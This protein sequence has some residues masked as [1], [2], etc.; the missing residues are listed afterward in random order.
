MMSF[1][2]IPFEEARK[3]EGE[4]ERERKWKKETALTCCVYPLHVC[5][6]VYTY[7]TPVWLHITVYMSIFCWASK[8]VCPAH[9]FSW[10]RMQERP[11]SRKLPSKH[12]Q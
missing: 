11:T 4:K 12:F 6:I 1:S 3:H 9:K 5:D 2:F 8:T 10:W 7:K